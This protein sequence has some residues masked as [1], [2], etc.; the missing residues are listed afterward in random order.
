[1]T[2]GTSGSADSN[3]PDCLGGKNKGPCV[4]AAC[5]RAQ[6]FGLAQYWL[7]EDGPPGLISPLRHKEL[8]L[9]VGTCWSSTPS[10]VSFNANHDHSS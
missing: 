4:K 9:D 5:P 3:G 6:W 8:V 7:S 1:M 2:L 10:R